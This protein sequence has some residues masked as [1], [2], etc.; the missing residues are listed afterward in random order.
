MTPANT[1]PKISIV[2]PSYNQGK[3][4]ERSIQSVLSQKYPLLE[5]FI[6]DGASSDNSVEIIKQHEHLLAHWVSEPDKGQADA[7]R[8]GFEWAT[9]DILGWLNSDD[10]LEPGA[11]E[12]IGCFF[13]ENP[14]IDLIIA[15]DVVEI[16]G[17]SYPNIPRNHVS[18]KH[19]LAGQILYQDAIFFRRSLY[20]KTTGINPD[21]WG[22]MDYDLWLKFFLG[23]ARYKLFPDKTISRFTMHPN[24]KSTDLDRYYKE[25][26]EISSQQ[27]K[28][29]FLVWHK[30]SVKFSQVHANLIRWVYQKSFF[31]IKPLLR[32]LYPNSWYFY[33]PQLPKFE[34]IQTGS[35][36]VACPICKE[37][38]VNLR[39]S[40]YDNRFNQP[41][42]YD[43]AWCNQCNVGITRPQLSSFELTQLYERHYSNKP[44]NDPLDIVV[45]SE[46]SPESYTN[47]P[48]KHRV[49]L[50]EIDKKTPKEQQKKLK[51][52]LKFILKPLLPK[53]RILTSSRPVIP[54]HWKG[55][56]LDFGCNDGEQLEIYSQLNQFNELWGLDI[57]PTAVERTR[58]R[59]FQAHC[60]DLRNVPWPENYFDVIV[61][62][63]VIEHVSNPVEVLTQLHRILKPNG[64]LLITCPN[65]ASFWAD[66][67]GLAWSH[68]HVPYHLFH[69]TPKS[70][71]SLASLAR[72][73][74]DRIETRS[75]AYWI[76]LS[77]H[78]NRYYGQ[79]EYLKIPIYPR[80][81]QWTGLQ[82]GFLQ[83]ISL[84][85]VDR[86][87][88]GDL[89]SIILTPIGSDS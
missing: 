9:G 13:A 52:L 20:F 78:L 72:F 56:L 26:K 61:L 74:V 62:S 2:S 79:G 51:I 24:Q 40:T 38:S 88:R 32:V 48:I 10:C 80:P 35:Q 22:A 65:A 89:L 64:Y 83:W 44:L 59:G 49:D 30:I 57:N 69:Y 12:F 4:L 86:L 63:Q 66:F 50:L 75:P 67:F 34:R 37:L 46:S 8:K 15:N 73:N 54:P 39:L 6:V 47:Q 25:I 81:N 16:N 70:I 1:Q 58:L 3:Y 42:I 84:L 17:W 28:S 53:L 71:S 55:K 45:G 14:D 7:L 33:T 43:I 87:Q 5:Y 41:G 31:G 68:W 85:S 82:A 29:H 76:F 11:L 21:F 60:G 77:Q 36:Q 19:L 27:N 18:I 23:Q